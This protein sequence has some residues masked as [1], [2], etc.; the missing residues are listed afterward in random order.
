MNVIET[1]GRIL[2][3]NKGPRAGPCS[4]GRLRQGIAERRS[5]KRPTVKRQAAICLASKSNSAWIMRPHSRT[6]EIRRLALECE[7]SGIGAGLQNA[8]IPI[9]LFLCHQTRVRIQP[10]ILAKF[11]RDAPGPSALAVKWCRHRPHPCSDT[12]RPNLHVADIG[13]SIDL[14]TAGLECAI[15]RSAHDRQII[16]GTSDRP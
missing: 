14:G 7:N 3:E 5:F 15:F 4:A 6:A 8:D 2:M 9:P 13:I 16:I 10:P 1:V 11:R 12:V